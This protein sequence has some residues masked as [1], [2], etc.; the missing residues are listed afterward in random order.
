MQRR[1]I[2]RADLDTLT[3]ADLI[4]LSADSPGITELVNA[5]C[6]TTG[7]V[8]LNVCYVNDIAVWGLSH[9]W[10]DRVLGLLNDSLLGTPQ[11][12]Q[13]SIS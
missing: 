13:S 8:W 10:C 4:V 5:H 11:G 2:N 1:I 7:Q 3:K 9:P 6:V 12:I